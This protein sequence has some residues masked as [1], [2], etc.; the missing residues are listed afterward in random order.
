[1]STPGPAAPGG[2]WK[3]IVVGYDGSVSSAHAVGYALRLAEFTRSEVF[4]VHAVEHPVDL[5]EPV[6]DEA[7]Q[8]LRRVDEETLAAL[9]REGSRRGL[10][11][12]C[13][14]RE[15][16]PV[17]AIL[18]AATERRADLIVVGTRGLRGAAKVLLGSVSSGVVAGARVPVTIV[19]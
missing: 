14:V 9:E 17:E 8:T 19:P 7:L 11:V 5:I 6:T 1:L 16:H 4:L 2:S 12:R 18:G 15:G 3:V 10:S 13:E